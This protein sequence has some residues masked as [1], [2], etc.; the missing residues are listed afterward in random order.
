MRPFFDLVSTEDRHVKIRKRHRLGNCAEIVHGTSRLVGPGLGRS[1]SAQNLEGSQDR[2]S[3][4]GDEVRDGSAT[5]PPKSCVTVQWLSFASYIV[6]FGAW[7]AVG[8]DDLSLTAK[9]R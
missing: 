2:I 4:V 9:M 8:A 5:V 3:T 7:S 1:P 6:G